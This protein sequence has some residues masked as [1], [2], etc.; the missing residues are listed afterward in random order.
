MSGNPANSGKRPDG[1]SGTSPQAPIS[2][3]GVGTFGMRLRAAKFALKFGLRSAR[4][5]F[6]RFPRSCTVCG[7]EGGFFAYGDPLVRDILC[8][9]CN[10]LERHRLLVLC[11]SERDLFAGKA[12]LHFAPEPSIAAHIARR[13]ALSY[14]TADLFAA[15]VDHKLNIEQIALGDGKFD[16]VLCNHVL[17]HVNDGKALREMHR[18][19]KPGGLLVAMFPIVEGWAETYENPA[20]KTEDERL[21]HFGQHDHVRFFASDARLRMADAGFRIEEFTATE[22]HV[23]RHG[24]SRGEKVFLC[25]K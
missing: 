17:E 5:L 8:P 12:I 6:G 22:P 3:A 10:S 11:D 9:S 20:V 21:L 7:Y 25:W 15:N 2:L 24:L 16:V 18:I 4:Y 14:E 23:S 19:L 13:G 1:I